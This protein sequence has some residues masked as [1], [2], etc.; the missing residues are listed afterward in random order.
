[1]VYLAAYGYAQGN[2]SGIFQGVDTDGNVCGNSAYTASG[3]NYAGYPYLYF[4]NLVNNG[5][6]KRVCVNTC[7]SWSGSAITQVNCPTTS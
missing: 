7:P 5:L 2:P 1:M 6:T 4:T 3:N